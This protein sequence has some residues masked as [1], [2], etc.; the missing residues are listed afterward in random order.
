MVSLSSSQVNFALP[1]H[2]VADA[3]SCPSAALAEVL[4]QVV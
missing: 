4:L 2:I 1:G 3:F